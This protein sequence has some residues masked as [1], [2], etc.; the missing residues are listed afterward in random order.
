MKRTLLIG[1]ALLAIA[2]TLVACAGGGGGGNGGGGGGGGTPTT[3]AAQYR[4]IVVPILSGSENMASAVNR[5]GQVIGTS[6][7]GGSERAYYWDSTN[8]LVTLHGAGNPA[9]ATSF[10]LGVNSQGEACGILNLPGSAKGFYALQSGGGF[11]DDDSADKAYSSGFAIN[12]TR[13][14]AGTR[15]TSFATRYPIVFNTNNVTSERITMN[16]T[17]DWVG[18]CTDINDNADIVGWVEN[19]GRQV[20][21]FRQSLG[22][23]TQI[24][25]P[26]VGEDQQFTALNGVRNVCGRRGDQA[27]FMAAGS[28]P[29]VIGGLVGSTLSE[30]HDISD[31]N[32]VVGHSNFGLLDRAFAWSSVQGMINLQTRLDA[33]GAGWVLNRANGISGDGRI[34]GV[35]TLNGVTRAFV[36]VPK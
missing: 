2:S 9:G 7:P 11:I 12:S 18:E 22:T 27:I 36:L 5:A 34:C 28:P 3:V 33:T 20:G 30:A 10:G 19:G 31:G 15:G 29:V 13:R 24:A 26:N 14:V 16:G 21:F 35:G 8:G 32:I 23:A 6:G 17:T 25:S 1:L 4:V